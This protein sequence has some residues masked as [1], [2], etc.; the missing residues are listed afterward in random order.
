MLVLPSLQRQ[1]Q[2]GHGD[3]GHPPGGSSHSQVELR[4]LHPTPQHPL[5]ESAD[6]DLNLAEVRALSRLLRPAALHQHSQL[7]T[8]HP[9]VNGGPEEGLLAVAYLLH[10][11]CPTSRGRW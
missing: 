7:L 3:R 4:P 10:N 6:E 8:V 1:G 2:L 11:L 9:S 5:V